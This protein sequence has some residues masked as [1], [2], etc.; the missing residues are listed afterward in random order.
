MIRFFL[1]IYDKMTRHRWVPVMLLLVLLTLSLVFAS[2]I[3]YQ[4]DISAFLPV[5]PETEE[6][7][8]VYTKLGGQDRV[9]IIFRGDTTQL[10]PAMD[11]YEEVLTASDTVG[12]VK[13]LLVTVDEERMLDVFKY[14]WQMYPLLLSDKDLCHLDSMVTSE[15]FVQRQMEENRRLLMLPLGSMLTQSLPFDPLHLSAFVTKDLQSNEVSDH[16]KIVDAHIFSKDGKCGIALLSSPYGISESKQNEKLVSLI[17]EVA[18]KVMDR[19]PD[20]KVS[21]IGAPVI[22]VGNA[23]QIKNDSLLAV[24]LS[25]LLIFAVLF[26]SFRRWSDI[27]WIGISIVFG[28]LVALG[29]ISVFYDN[30]SIIVLG[31]GSVIIGI[32][33]NYPLHFLDHLRHEVN[34]RNALKEMVTPLLIGNVTTVS[35][36]LCLVFIDADA[37]RDLGIFGSLMLIAT[38]AFVLI[39]LPA[40]VSRRTEGG[41]VYFILP[42]VKFRIPHAFRKLL[43]PVVIVLTII[44]GYLSLGTSFDSNVQ[45]INYMTPEQQE[46]LK[47]LFTSVQSNDSLTSVFAVSKG[48][49]LDDALHANERLQA[50]IDD[51]PH[52]HKVYGIN[53]LVPS[54]ERLHDRMDKWTA[55]WERHSDVI[56]HTKQEAERLG[57]SSVAFSPFFDL[58]EGKVQDLDSQNPLLDLIGRNY[59][60]HNAD[61][62]VRIVNILQIEK[63][64]VDAVKQ[65]LRTDIKEKSMDAFVFDST[66]VSSSL[67]TVLSDSFNYIGF[68]CGFVVFAFL[69][70]SFGRLELSII[71]FLPLAVSWLWIL[72]FMDIFSIQFNIVNIILATFIFGQGDDYSIFITEGLT[73]E[74]AYGRARLK[75]YKNSV[76]LSAVLMFIGIGTLILAQHPAL[77]SL[78]EVAIIGMVTVVLMTFYLPPLV[79]RWLT[80]KRGVF[81][82]IPITID[83]LLCSIW[84][85]SFFLVFSLL[86]FEPYALFQRYV[87]YRSKRCREFFHKVLQ[88]ISRYVIYRVP[89]VKF[90]Y[91]NEVKETF[92]KPAVIICNHQS[93]LDV[94]CLL[95]M[96]PKI[97]ILT[98]DW[99]WHNPFYGAIIR[100]AEFYPISDGVD[101][102]LPRLA[103][104]VSR[105]YSVVVFPEGTRETGHEIMRFHKGAFFLAKTLKV[106]IL[107]VMLHGLSDV[108]PKRDFMLRRG[109]ITVEVHKR[110][111]FDEMAGY[112]DRALRTHW[113]NW[114]VEHYRAMRNKCE[115]VEYCLPLVKYKYVYKGVDVEHRCK[116][117]LRTVADNPAIIRQYVAGDKTIVIPDSGQGEIAWI[118]ALTHPDHEV[119]A[120]E[121]D[122]DLHAIAINTYGIPSNLHFINQQYIAKG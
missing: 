55:F 90:Q 108:L 26:Y 47:L 75:S 38:I 41:K 85:M 33:V 44:L 46:N 73:Y 116:R 107:P 93:H 21:S 110:M 34:C 83:R 12:M 6:Y 91:I 101:K 70:L 115:D 67:V 77:R 39:I 97:V 74:Y 2:Q 100:A 22:A 79:F 19:Y 105:G 68:V 89:G 48:E 54:S 62:S 20:I 7:T 17:D 15:G 51:V 84:A 4:E 114:Y 18:N 5:D 99:V 78:A 30:I 87:L 45:H 37:M 104:L 58:C 56:D 82:E 10:I 16:Y 57:F 59:I 106:D 8:T 112:D 95:M 36:F 63:N 9:A 121:P 122:E 98:N 88:A 35:A 76:M 49:N 1:R 53:G 113:Y 42:D 94:M 120:Y 117:M 65:L 80:T 11:Y 31:I 111:T 72:G 86:V 24:S 23:S 50:L 52:V 81:R 28:W 119:Y 66:D 118:A 32:A 64:Q 71:S 29:V 13:D 25:V 61:G 60:L 27:F 69:W 96:S 109:K 103:D 3:K 92:D 14:V 102:N 40:L 43:L